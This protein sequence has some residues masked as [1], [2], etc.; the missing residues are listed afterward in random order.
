MAQGYQVT[1]ITHTTAPNAAGDHEAAYEVHYTT[2]TKPPVSGSVTV[3]ASLA[4]DREAYTSTVKAKIDAETAG[5][6][7]VLSL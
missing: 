4:S 2:K 1:K 5:H 7:A 6:A 3:P